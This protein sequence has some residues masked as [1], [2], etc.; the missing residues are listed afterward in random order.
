[1]VPFAKR[2]KK[3]LKIGENEKTDYYYWLRDDNRE[4][5]EVLDYLNA[6]NSFADEQMMKQGI[7]TEKNK[8]TSILRKK[9]VEDWETSKLPKSKEGFNS[10]YLFF[11][12]FVKNNGYPLYYYVH[13]NEQTIYCDPNKI[14]KE[15]KVVDVTP[16]YFDS[17]LRIVGWGV[18][19]NG[20]E[21]YDIK[22][23]YF[24]S[25][26]PVQHQIPPILYSNFCLTSNYVFYGAHDSANRVYQVRSYDIKTKEDKLIYEEPRPEKDIDFYLSSE[27]NHLFYGWSDSDQNQLWCH[28]LT[29]K[30]KDRLVKKSKR[31]VKYEA[32]IYNDKFVICGDLSKSGCNIYYDGMPYFENLED[33]QI[34]SMS[35]TKDGVAVVMRLNGALSLVFINFLTEARR[36]FNASEETCSVDIIYSNPNSNDIVYSLESMTEPLKMY[37]T[38]TELE[39]NTLF[40]EHQTKN[41]D[42]TQYET[43]RHWVKSGNVQVPIDIITKK[44][45]K[46]DKVLLYGYGCYG[47]NIDCDFN[48]LIF[49]LIDEGYDY[50]VAHVRGS[51]FMSKK[52]Y[53]EGKMKKKM[54]SFR[55]FNNA[56]RF[57]KKK[58]YKVSCSGRS[59]GG[60]LVA[61]S[62]V[63][64]PKLYEK[65]IAVVPFVDVLTTMS[66]ET[67]PLTT[68]EW[69]EIGNPNKKTHWN[70]IKKYSPV[71]NI[72]ENTKY[73]SYF[74][75]GGLHD[76]RVAYWEPAKFVAN[77]R[78]ANKET[79]IIFKTDMESGHFKANDR[80]EMINE[81]AEEYAFLLKN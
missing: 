48:W 7:L 32:D 41:Y 55:D 59:A 58:G 80:Y 39:N 60:L 25:M 37:K 46:T 67:I 8:L 47:T 21:V 23:Y 17:D 68:G 70:Y 18:D 75:R 5:K 63:L 14:C 20:S 3:T 62:S 10:D 81:Y 24:P 35:L 76:P 42:K 40:Y 54:N 13:N 79:P 74:I 2:Q 29:G 6:E 34:E 44:N 73:P 64:A 51:T 69:L 77:L 27:G 50:A 71:D 4:D 43:K 36:F 53:K 19:K 56:A 15:Q 28:S 1:M 38:N 16:P 33:R 78:Y 22:L 11:K 30:K 61:A 65:V 49:A 12:K 72:K 9:L 52:W 66:D 26:K 45:R 31:D 57:L